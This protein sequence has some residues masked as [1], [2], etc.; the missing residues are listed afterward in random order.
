MIKTGEKVAHEY[1][2]S[3]K[4]KDSYPGSVFKSLMAI[5]NGKKYFPDGAKKMNAEYVTIFLIRVP[6]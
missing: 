2:W 5:D 1:E 3:S 6:K 4:M